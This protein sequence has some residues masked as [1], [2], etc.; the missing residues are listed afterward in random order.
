MGPL[1]PRA[2]DGIG[3]T[4][5]NGA[6]NYFLIHRNPI[7][8]AE[9]YTQAFLGL[10]LTC[11]RCHNHPLEKWTQRDYY[12]FAN[13]FARV[14]VKDDDARSRPRAT[15]RSVFSAD[16]GEILHPRLGVA[17]PPRPLDGVPMSAD[18]RE[19]RRA[20]VAAWLTSPSNTQF[21]RAIVN[22][23]WGNLFG[24]GLVHPMD[25]LRVTNPASNERAV[26][27]ADRRLRRA[28]VRREAR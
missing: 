9:N 27:S 22:R 4:D 13:L 16:D 20:Y 5:Q 1:R 6:A 25:D 19:D 18:A 12:Q 3:R 21:A 15:R 23:V 26:R 8:L 7:D 17:L 24:R 11:A 2:D 14:S 10:T 28:R